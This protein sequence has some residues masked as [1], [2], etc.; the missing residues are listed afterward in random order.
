MKSNYTE[1]DMLCYCLACDF[2]V[3]LLP[4]EFSKSII[5]GNILREYKDQMRG[6]LS[7][8]TRERIEKMAYTLYALAES[9]YKMEYTDR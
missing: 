2:A 3:E 9:D 7:F 1:L 4:D 8:A 5:M 6:G